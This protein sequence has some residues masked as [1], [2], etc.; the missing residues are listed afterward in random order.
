MCTTSMVK[1]KFLSAQSELGVV[2]VGFSGGQVS[3]T[4]PFSHLNFTTASSTVLSELILTSPC[5]NKQASTSGR[6]P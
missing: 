2:A 3:S 4:L 5:R 1:S 6:P